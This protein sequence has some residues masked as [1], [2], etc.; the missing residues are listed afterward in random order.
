M[1]A[2]ENNAFSTC[3]RQLG[4]S[5]PKPRA[6]L[7]IS[8]HWE[9]RD[10]K[11]SSVAQPRTIHDFYAFPPQLYAMQY[12]APG[13]PQLAEQVVELLG[14]SRVEPDSEWGLDHGAWA[15]LCH[16]FP[17][18]DIPV[19]QLSL[20][21][22]KSG[23]EHYAL[24]QLLAPLRDD[25]VLIVGSGNLVHNLGRLRWEENV[26]PYPWAAAFDRK[27]AELIAAG[28]HAALIDYARLGAEAQ[29]A[30]P[31]AE[32]YV[33]LLYTLAQQQPGEPVSFFAAEVVLASISMRGVRVG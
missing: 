18:A 1:N 27:A 22:G 21:R 10:T 11:V 6:I 17:Q 23:A 33:P 9:T 31:T 13:S 32:H 14:P 3:W 12:P 5:L 24:A 20:D 30:I 29:L 15:V 16:M 2:I 28:D 8:A 26:A 25:G 4:A 7:C 19:V